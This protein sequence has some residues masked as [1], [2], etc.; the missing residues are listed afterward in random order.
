MSSVIHL[1]KEQQDIVNHKGDVLCLACPGSGKTRVLVQRAA[2]LSKYLKSPEYVYLLTFT[3]KAA[4]E[5]KERLDKLG[6]RRVIVGTIHKLAYRILRGIN[7]YKK[8]FILYDGD[9]PTTDNTYID[10]EDVC[11]ANPNIR[12]VIM[13]CKYVHIN[14]LVKDFQEYLDTNSAK[15]F[16]NTV[17]HVLVDEVQDTNKEQFE[18]IIKLAQN[19]SLTLVGDVNQCIYSFQNANP[20]YLKTYFGKDGLRPMIVKKITKNFRNPVKVQKLSKTLIKNKQTFKTKLY[21]TYCE[22]FLIKSYLRTYREDGDS[23]VILCRVRWYLD[24][25]KANL[26]RFIDVEKEDIEFMTCHESKGTEKDIVVIV[27]CHDKQFPH[28]KQHDSPEGIEEECRVLYV[29]MT[30]AKKRVM[31]TSPRF[32]NMRPVEPSRF[33]SGNIKY[34]EKR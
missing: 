28:H 19:K 29:G 27:G 16:L 12:K 20:S 23:V 18:V 9:E 6:I 8:P 21:V 13:D 14:D 34:C 7:Y 24:M 32:V 15:I 22:S 11:A 2:K 4:L 31:F 3:K 10:V 1:H 33:L 17:A 25:I 26:S 30:R 5:M